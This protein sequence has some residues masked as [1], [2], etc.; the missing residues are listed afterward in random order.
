MTRGTWDEVEGR[1]RLDTQRRKE[2]E[3]AA[4]SEHRD[5][6]ELAVLCRD[7]LGTDKGRRL[8]AWLRRRT[9]D[10][11]FGPGVSESALWYREGQRQLVDQLERATA[12]GLAI[13]AEQLRDELPK[14]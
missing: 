1:R 14:D 5:A 4:E 9:K 8:L 12:Q 7:A 3:L 13:S 10:A 2:A 11:V 6:A